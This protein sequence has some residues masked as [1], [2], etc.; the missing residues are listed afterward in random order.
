V[1]LRRNTGLGFGS[2]FDFGFGFDLGAVVSSF[3]SFP[4]LGCWEMKAWATTAV[5]AAAADSNLLRFLAKIGSYGCLH[6]LA[7]N[8]WLHLLCDV[9][10]WDAVRAP[11]NSG[12]ELFCNLR[13][14]RP[15]MLAEPIVLWGFGLGFGFEMDFGFGVVS[16]FRSLAAESGS[17]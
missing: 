16:S 7:D 1:L 9:G 5:L 8:S 3:L 17:C 12:F 6:D 11:D 14:I 15:H 2:D 4:G 10:S 13:R